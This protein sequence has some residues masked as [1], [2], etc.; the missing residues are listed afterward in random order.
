[1][2]HKVHREMIDLLMDF[3]FAV[4]TVC[5]IPPVAFQL[6]YNGTNVSFSRWRLFFNTPEM[7][8][9][10]YLWIITFRGLIY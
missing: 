10:E 5:S 9:H 7:I 6:I 2:V 3:A 4:L 1:M 8:R